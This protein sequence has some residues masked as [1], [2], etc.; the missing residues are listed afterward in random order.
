MFFH[1]FKQECGMKYII[2]GMVLCAGL[3]EQAVIAMARNKR[4]LQTLV[5]TNKRHHM[6]RSP[7]PTSSSSDSERSTPSMQSDRASIASTI[8]YRDDADIFL[9]D[10]EMPSL[11]TPTTTIV[12]ED[13]LI[14]M[15]TFSVSFPCRYIKHYGC[16]QRFTDVK[17]EVAHIVTYHDIVASEELSTPCPLWQGLDTVQHDI[18]IT[19]AALAPKSPL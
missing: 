11:P 9:F 17:E 5:Q 19:V 6:V 7:S 16:R 1:L 3:Y 14:E 4:F 13:P 15:V 2:L 8:E 10:E 18:D 12:S